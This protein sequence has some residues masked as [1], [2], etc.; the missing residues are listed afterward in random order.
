MKFKLLGSI[1]LSSILYADTSVYDIG[2]IEVVDSNN[3]SENKTKE[4][5]DSEVILDTNSKNVVEALTNISGV[6]V[7]KLGR[8]NQTDVRVRGFTSEFIPIYIDGIPVY[9]PYD[10][11]TDLSRYT[12]ADVSEI[13]LSKS[14]VSPMFGANTLGGAINIV[15]KKPTKE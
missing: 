6:S 5:V 2:R 15:T 8:K 9:T 10:R 11:G 4:V 13:S 1:V 12:T 14:Y 7:Q 3:V